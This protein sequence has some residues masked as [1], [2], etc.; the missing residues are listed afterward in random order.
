M[1]EHTD[2]LLTSA[3]AVSGNNPWASITT[4]AIS[5]TYNI[6]MI[7]Q[8]GYQLQIARATNYGYASQEYLQSIRREKIKHTVLLGLDIAPLLLNFLSKLD[9]KG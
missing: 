8:Y 9:R 2:I 4:H 6:S 5:M 3:K 1:K 7:G